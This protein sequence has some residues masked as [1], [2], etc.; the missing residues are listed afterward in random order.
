VLSGDPTQPPT[1]APQILVPVGAEGGH[2]GGRERDRRDPWSLWVLSG[3]AGTGPDG[4]LAAVVPGCL[5]GPFP[6][7]LVF[8]AA[9]EVAPGSVAI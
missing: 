4:V 2:P 6:T 1:T 5:H 9:V 7:S 3:A 8:T